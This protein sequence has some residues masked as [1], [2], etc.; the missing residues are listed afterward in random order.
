MQTT[1][2]PVLIPGSTAITALLPNGDSRRRF[3]RFSEKILIEASSAFSLN[4][5]ISSFSRDG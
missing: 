1:L 5:D 4:A 3:L 2:L